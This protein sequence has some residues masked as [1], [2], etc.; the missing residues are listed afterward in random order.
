MDHQLSVMFIR[1]RGTGAHLGVAMIQ[2]LLCAAHLL[3]MLLVG[4]LTGSEPRLAGAPGWCWTARLSP[5]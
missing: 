1:G 2:A 3:I 5:S 4:W